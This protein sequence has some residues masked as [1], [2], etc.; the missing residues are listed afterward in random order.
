MPHTPA[1]GGSMA[2]LTL[3]WPSSRMVL[4]ACRSSVSAMARRI[5][6]SSNGGFSR[7]TIRLVATPVKRM[8]H[9]AL[10]ASRLTFLSS[11]TDTSVGNVMSNLPLVKASMRVERSG[12]IVYSIPS[13]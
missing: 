11:G 5:F 4:K 2:P 10:G 1:G 8:V 9:C 12:M 13:R 7:L 3:L 6:S